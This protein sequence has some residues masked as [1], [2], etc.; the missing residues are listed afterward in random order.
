MG[1]LVLSGALNA[2]HFLGGLLALWAVTVTAIGLRSESFP[3]TSRQTLLVGG[4]SVVLTVGAISS[5]IIEG[6]LKADEHG[7]AEAA[8]KPAEQA[9]PVPAGALRLAADPTGEL[10]FDKSK[11][12]ARA[13]KVAIAMTNRSTVTHDVSLEGRGVDKHGKLVKGGGT[14]TVSAELKHG[15]YT[16]YCSVPGHRAGGMEGTLTVK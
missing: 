10:K 4:I 3:R 6:A 1:I 13:G 15:R 14:S 9:A 8:G 11:L 16:F 2:F 12:E 7:S 5:A